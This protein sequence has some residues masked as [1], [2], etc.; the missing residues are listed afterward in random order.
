MHEPDDGD[1]YRHPER[2]EKRRNGVPAQEGSQLLDIGQARLCSASCKARLDT[3][4]DHRS[5]QF[6]LK[7][8]A[9][10]GQNPPSRK[11]ELY[12]E[13]LR[14]WGWPEYAMPTWIPSH[15]H[16][17][18]LDFEAGERILVPTFRLPTMIHTRGG[19]SKWLNEISHGHPLWIHPSDA[20]RLGIEV[21][22]LVRVTTRL[23]WFV[24]RAWRTE[25]IRPGVVGASH[26]MG[27]WRLDDAGGAQRWSSGRV[28]I[29]MS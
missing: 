27:R 6:V 26:H 18:D 14:D 25:G 4:A 15:V 22:G 9:R 3:V 8:G 5:R 16:W 29:T 28:A 11:L 7:P 2:I 13:M 24:I 10:Q 19:N 21:D 20:E 23:G 17:E 1:E 12:S